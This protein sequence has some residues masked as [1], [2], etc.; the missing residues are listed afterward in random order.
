MNLLLNIFSSLIFKT[1]FAYIY[2]KFDVLCY[3]EHYEKKRLS[4]WFWRLLFWEKDIKIFGTLYKNAV[5]I[6]RVLHSLVMIIYWFIA[7]ILFYQ[8]F[9]WYIFIIDAVIGVAWAYY[10]MTFERFYYRISN[11]LMDLFE[12]Q[13]KKLDVFW[14]K[15]I[16]FSGHWLFQKEFIVWHFDLS[17]AIG[18]A[19]MYLT[20]IIYFII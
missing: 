2:P 16:Y 3:Y 15:R 5:P 11:T 7:W 1:L 6:Y 12:Y 17:A 13:I 8:Y 20:S 10:F 19:I 9:A 4:N 14:L 18:L